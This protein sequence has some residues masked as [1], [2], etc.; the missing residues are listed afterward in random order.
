M[1]ITFVLPFSG[2]RPG[3]GIKVVYA[4][5]NNLVARG[6][7][8]RIV[9]PAGLYLGVDSN[10]RWFS[11]VV[12]YVLL[13][14]TKKYLPTDWYRLDRKVR[15]LWRPSLAT[16]FIPDADIVVATAWGTAEW[17]ARYP[18]RK[19][20]KYYLI[21]GFENWSADT[22]RVLNTWRL[23]LRKIVIS[24]W[25][26]A[27][28]LSLNETSRYI[29]NGLDFLKFGVDVAPEQRDP[30][31]LLMLYHHLDIKGT[32][33]GL[34]VL[35]NLKALFPA[36]KVTLFGVSAPGHGELP[37]WMTF[38][39]LPSQKRLRVLYNQAAIFVSPSWSE[40]WALPPAEAMQCGCATVLTDIGGHEYAID[41]KTSLLSPPKDVQQ[42]TDNLAKLLQDNHNRVQLAYA[43]VTEIAQYTWPHATQSLER[44]FRE[45]D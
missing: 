25:L 3:G 13:G 4:Y 27:I 36:I 22:E 42:M 2:R 11:N 35:R 45:Q 18:E 31:Q 16:M 33:E 32:K 24:R 39:R 30:N 41:G 17:V 21:Q 29:P 6:H 43:A 7:D 14:I 9:H 15:V 26:E 44:Y 28:A 10:D 34:Q 1:N 20:R 23:P 38:E 12:K 40:G 37:D 8:V 5:A 19:G